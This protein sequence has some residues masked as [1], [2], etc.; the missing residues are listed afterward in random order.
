MLLEKVS[1]DLSAPQALVSV[2]LTH[3]L[4]RLTNFSV[5]FC[6]GPSPQWVQGGVWETPW[7]KVGDIINDV[8][9]VQ[10]LCLSV[11]VC[12]ARKHRGKISSM[13]FFWE[14]MQHWK[15]TLH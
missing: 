7:Q 1:A 4:S 10:T 2:L 3:L 14:I 6:I 13:V 8:F 11:S 9:F 5:S 12:V 15:T